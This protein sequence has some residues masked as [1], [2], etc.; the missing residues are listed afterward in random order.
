M[1]FSNWIKSTNSFKASLSTFPEDYSLKTLD[2]F[3]FKAGMS[4]L[5]HMLYYDNKEIVE[6]GFSVGVGFKF[7]PVGNQ[8][9]LSYYF[10]NREY[11][12]FEEKEFIQQIQI[13]ISLADIWFVKRR[14]K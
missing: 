5:K 2:K 10:G 6:L 8:V 14:Q 9:D 13:G 11:S 12:G 1:P 4:Y 3:S 7:K